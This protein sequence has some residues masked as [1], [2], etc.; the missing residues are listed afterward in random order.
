M[1]QSLAGGLVV[2]VMV[3]VGTSTARAQTTLDPVVSFQASCS[4]S[5]GLFGSCGGGFSNSSFYFA[6]PFSPGLSV[7]TGINQFGS[8]GPLPFIVFAV[9]ATGGA[10]TYDGA[11]CDN[12]DLVNGV[13]CGGVVVLGS[14]KVDTP[15]DA[16]LSPGTVVSESGPGSMQGFF[17]DPCDGFS[18]QVAS[19]NV[20]A[21]YQFTLT[22][23]GTQTPWSWTGAKFSSIAPTPEPPTLLLFGTGLLI[24]GTIACRKFQNS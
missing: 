24:F 3:I 16:G 1:R 23:P 2:A 6:G 8:G 10:I 15:N 21:T 9:G 5:G 17:C 4:I 14:I 12:S 18:P 20:T 19:A 7:G 13:S 11:S 22:A